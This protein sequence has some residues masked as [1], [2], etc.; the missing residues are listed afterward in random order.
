M[1]WPRRSTIVIKHRT[2]SPNNIPY[3]G[4]AEPEEYKYDATIVPRMTHRLTTS[5]KGFELLVGRE[6][7]SLAVVLHIG[8]A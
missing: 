4:T 6:K 3:Q 8:E 2:R 1:D 5:L 7:L